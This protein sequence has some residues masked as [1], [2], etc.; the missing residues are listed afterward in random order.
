MSA[1]DVLEAQRRSL[2]GM[3][4]RGNLRA[5]PDELRILTQDEIDFE[6][7]IRLSLRGD[8]GVGAYPPPPKRSRMTRVT[9]P[10]SIW[11]ESLCDVVTI[12]SGN[13]VLEPSSE[14]V[15]VDFTRTYRDTREFSLH[16]V[17][18]D[19]SCF[20]HAA[21]EAMRKSSHLWRN[22]IDPSPRQGGPR[23]FCDLVVKWWSKY[24]TTIPEVV[25]EDNVHE[26]LNYKF[27][28][29]ITAGSIT[30]ES[31]ETYASFTGPDEP[32]LRHFNTKDVMKEAVMTERGYFA[33][34]FTID[35]LNRTLSPFI[36]IVVVKETFN[37]IS[38]PIR[39]VRHDDNRA[40]SY[41]WVLLRG[42]HYY[43]MR[44]TGLHKPLDNSFLEMIPSRDNETL[45]YLRQDWC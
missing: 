10:P 43:L 21:I 42:N 15:K 32:E 36:K 26:H 11:D 27:L 44:K 16:S 9:D 6:K 13:G 34:D 1:E 7:A 2:L 33:D 45:K 20:F 31:F 41:L 4:Q 37:G 14:T 29:Y 30:D 39:S 24:I 19:G 18:G 22:M 35:I 5:E 23:T 40:M 38:P 25:S 8:R 17:P 12:R 3:K 28:R